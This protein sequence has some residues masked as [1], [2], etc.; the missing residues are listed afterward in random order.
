MSMPDSVYQDLVSV[1]DEL[2]EMSKKPMSLSMAVYLLIAVFRAHL[3]NPCSRDA[4]R[5]K[6]ASSDFMS[7][8]EFE[9]A[10]DVTS[11]ESPKKVPKKKRKSKE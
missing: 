1:A 5:Q 2:E 9:I 7:P 10:W 4:F 6:M 8:E 11:K 3:S